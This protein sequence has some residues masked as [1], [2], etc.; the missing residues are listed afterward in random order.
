[1]NQ[2]AEPYIKRKAVRHLEKRR[3]VIFGAGTGNPFFTTDTA[4]SLRAIEINAD[5]VL[6]A[7]KVDGVYDKDPVKHTDAKLYDKLTYNEVLEKQ[8][9]VM[10]LTA[11]VLCKE[12]NMP[13]KVFNILK[14]GNVNGYYKR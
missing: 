9:G 2:I 7:T 1:M 6:K 11:I 8:L 10:D 12:N 4:A 5:M 3:I 13:L 14:K